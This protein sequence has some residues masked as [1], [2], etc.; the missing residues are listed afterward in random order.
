MGHLARAFDKPDTRNFRFWHLA[1]VLNALTN[2]RF[3]EQTGH[4]PTAAT[5]LDFEPVTGVQER[6]NKVDP[7][8]ELWAATSED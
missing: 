1:D 5:N 8:G 3:R 6:R 4:W 7:T 2:V